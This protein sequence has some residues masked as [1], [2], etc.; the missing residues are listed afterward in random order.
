MATKQAK[1]SSYTVI[2]EP[3]EDGGYTVLVPALPGCITEG[4]SLDEAKK[5][6]VEAI[7]CY[8]EGLVIEGESIPEDIKTEPIYEKIVVELP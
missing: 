7:E 1:Q 2:F 5:N 8:L 4:D 3:Q 6:A